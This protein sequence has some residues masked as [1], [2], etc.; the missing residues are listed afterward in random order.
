MS[1]SSE[2]SS[3]RWE[4]GLVGLRLQASPTVSLTFAHRVDFSRP[5]GSGM[6]SMSQI[7]AASPTSASSNDT[8]TADATNAKGISQIS[9]PTP[10]SGESTRQSTAAIKP[11]APDTEADS[12]INIRSTIEAVQTGHSH[13]VGPQLLK[14][15]GLQS[16]EGI[17]CKQLSL[18]HSLLRPGHPVP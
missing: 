3:P 6:K 15:R 5:P 2:Q 10:F 9:A 11:S 8:E 17:A 18:A 13:D 14:N 7:A 12:L 16:S 1:G 4:P